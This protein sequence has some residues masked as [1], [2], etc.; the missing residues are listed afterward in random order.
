MLRDAV[1]ERGATNESREEQRRVY[2]A[3]SFARDG[4]V[5]RKE[6]PTTNTTIVHERKARSRIFRGTFTVKNR[7]RCCQDRDKSVWSVDLRLSS[8]II[9]GVRRV[10]EHACAVDPPAEK[11][12]SA[13]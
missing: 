4:I 2:R 13:A 9:A 3:L 12:I 10:R 8:R 11:L 1:A 7:E 6:Q 5:S